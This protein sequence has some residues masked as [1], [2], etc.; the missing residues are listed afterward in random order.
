[1][2][3]ESAGGGHVFGRKMQNTLVADADGGRA[4]RRINE[5]ENNER[6]NEFLGRGWANQAGT[7]GKM[8][9]DS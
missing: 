4:H 8:N 5:G 9:G 3:V 6:E 1:M 2:Q 7:A